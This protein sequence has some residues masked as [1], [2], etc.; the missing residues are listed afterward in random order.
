MVPYGQQLI[1]GGQSISALQAEK[2]IGTV[3]SE[4]EQHVTNEFRRLGRGASAT[5]LAVAV[6]AKS[7]GW[8]DRQRHSKG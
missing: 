6:E 2:R 8:K 7:T 1:T 5:I 4:T 3:S